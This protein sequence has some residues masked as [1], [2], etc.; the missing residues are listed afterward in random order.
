MTDFLLLRG[1]N[2]AAVIDVS[3]GV[4]R[5]VHWGSPLDEGDLDGLADAQARAVPNAELDSVAPI[6]IVPEH[7]SGFF[8]RAGLQGH[9]PDGSS[10]APRF[11]PRSIEADTRRLVVTASD[12]VAELTL[13]TTLELDASDV[14]ILSISL[15]NDG[16][17]PF[18]VDSLTATLPLPGRAEEV[19]GFAGRWSNEFQPYR[20]RLRGGMLSSENRKGRTSHDRVPVVFI[21]TQGFSH[22][23][24]DVWGFHLGWSGNTQR[25]VELLADGRRYIQIGELLHPGEVE[26]AAGESLEAPPLYC[27]YSAV[28]LNGTTHAYHRYLRGRG[29]LPTVDRP[30]PVLLNTWEAVYFNHDLDTLKGLADR[31]SAIGVERFVLDDGWFHGRRDDTAGLGDWWV[32]TTVWPN[33]LDPIIEH[34]RGLGMEFGIWVEPEMVN[35]DSDLYREHPEWALTTEGYEAPLG[36]NQL[37]LDLANPAAYAYILDK[38]DRLLTDHD[39]DYVKW[40]MNRDIVQGSGTD[41]RA[42]VRAQTLAV[43]SLFAEL[44]GRHPAVEIESCSSGGARADFAVLEST[45]RVWTS[46]C[47][48][49]LERHMIQ[50]GFS[51]LFPPEV[52]GAH[53]GPTRS[54]T[55]NRQHDLSFRAGTALFG[56]LGIEWNLLEAT[57][58]DRAALAEVIEIHKRYRPMLHSGVA[59]GVD[60]PDDSLRIHGVT[61]ADRSAGLF[62]VAKLRGGAAA[63]SSPMR[64]AGLDPDRRYLVSHVPL[65]GT[66]LGPHRALP[67]WFESGVE[68]TGRA[69]A[70]VGIEL[71]AQ[72][73]ETVLLFDVTAT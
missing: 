43:Y 56:H 16:S 12:G 52:M 67:A 32:D 68:L 22:E 53:I 39:V 59:V 51:L 3:L 36:R 5:V 4:P 57:D 17:Q 21:G 42:G 40:D 24:G 26:L 28:G 45:C 61:D 10:W 2:V 71:P 41:G 30:R 55:T 70:T 31:A 15:R 18:Q 34:V 8:G 33:G 38:L 58:E 60:H 25:H 1:A 27:T 49:A 11:A 54:H 35:P 64:L 13:V 14:L 6:S 73:P 63:L 44:A 66:R 9:R 29:N 72:H 62:A 48:D 69:L 19:L 37:V 23:G 46:D 20:Q 50:E 47:N 7:G 65:P